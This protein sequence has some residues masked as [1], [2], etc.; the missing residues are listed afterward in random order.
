MTTWPAR[1]AWARSQRTVYADDVDQVADTVSPDPADYATTEQITKAVDELN[2]LW[3]TLGQQLRAANEAALRVFPLHG[4]KPRSRAGA[5]AWLTLR[6]ALPADQRDIVDHAVT[7]KDRRR[8]ISQARTDLEDRRLTLNRSIRALDIAAGSCPTYAGLVQ[9]WHAQQQTA[10][11]RY[12]AQVAARPVDDNAWRAELDRRA[13][14]A[15]TRARGH[16]RRA[17]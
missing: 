16:L 2:T 1:N 17:G 3:R 15:L 12:R 4:S 13:D 8:W 6:D 5:H 10:V 9:R 11:D 7:I 14:I